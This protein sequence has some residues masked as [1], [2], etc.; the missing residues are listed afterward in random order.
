MRRL[1]PSVNSTRLLQRFVASAS[2]LQNVP[3]AKTSAKLGTPIPKEEVAR[4]F[5]V[6]AALLEKA[7]RPGEILF[8]TVDLA[9]SRFAPLIATLTAEE[10]VTKIAAEVRAAKS[11][12]AAAAAKA[13]AGAKEKFENTAWASVRQLVTF[14][15]EAMYPIRVK[16]QEYKVHELNSFHIKDDLKRGLSAFKQEHLDKQKTELV[17][18][19]K[20][21]Q[22]CQNFIK[23]VTQ[24]SFNTAIL[25]DIANILRICGERNPH[26]HR[27][28]LQVLEDMSVLAVPF[29]AVTEKLLH[30][31]V[32][33]DGAVDDS[34]LLFT[35]LEYPER[36]E[37]S[38]GTAPVDQ[39]ADATLRVISKRHHTPL[40]S[41]DKGKL[42][43]QKDTHPCL[44]RSAE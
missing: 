3:P 2:V 4:A 39:I 29:D 41:N 26:A 20:Q 25:N 12:D 13:L 32:F 23:D 16:L 11:G 8:T 19:Q 24:S 35:L 36:G 37:V 21:M 28:S 33:D 31:A 40:D 18:V 30:A 22:E 6:P 14:Y 15:E 1:V 10:D 43:R 27:M 34:A 42:L 5:N 17:K 9:R 38:V 44:Q 7:C